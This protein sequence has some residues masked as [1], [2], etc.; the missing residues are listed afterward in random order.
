MLRKWF[1]VIRS[2]FGRVLSPVPVEHQGGEGSI[3][4]DFARQRREQLQ[5]ETHRWGSFRL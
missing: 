5:L 4:R 1:G 3:R 2:W